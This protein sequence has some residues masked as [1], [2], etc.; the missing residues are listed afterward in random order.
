MAIALYDNFVLENKM[1]DLVNSN[2]DVNS[3]FTLD[4][5]LEGSAGLKKT[6]NK[7]TYSGKVEKLAKGDG[8]GRV[9][10]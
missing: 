6:I 7:Y 1:T 8:S 9:Q 4:N 5:S 2:V 10:R 3:L